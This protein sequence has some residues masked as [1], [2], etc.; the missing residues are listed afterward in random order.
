M[1]CVSVTG[2]RGGARAEL[3]AV[4]SVLFLPPGSSTHRW[5]SSAPTL[6]TWSFPE[7]FAVAP[8]EHAQTQLPGTLPLFLPRLQSPALPI[9][10]P[11]GLSWSELALSHWVYSHHCPRPQNFFQSLPFSLVSPTL[12]E[13]PSTLDS[14]LR[15]LHTPLAPD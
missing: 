15:P 14:R 1:Q 11:L 6:L 2:V 10:S 12:S 9:T 4:C 3:E 13:S 5:G 7:G 8:G